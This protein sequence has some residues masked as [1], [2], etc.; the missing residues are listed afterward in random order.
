M[1]TLPRPGQ[2]ER[3]ALQF[4][5]LAS[6]VES[7]LG[8]QHLGGDPSHGERMLHDVLRQRGLHLSRTEDA[9]LS[10]AVRVGSAPTTLRR[11]AAARRQR[12]SFV[13]TLWAG[14]RYPMALIATA[15]LVALISLRLG[16]SRWVPI[17]IVLLLVATAALAFL[18]VRGLRRGTGPW[19]RLP[20]L[21]PLLEQ[22]A[23]LPYLQVLHGLY[24]AGVPLLTAHPQAV[25]ACPLVAVRLRLFA[26]DRIVQQQRPL[27]EAL[28]QVG[29][30][31][32]ETRQLIRTGEPGG[33]LED[34]LLRALQRRMD[35]TSRDTLLF[36]QWLGRIA[37]GTAAAIAIYLIFSFYSAY[38]SQLNALRGR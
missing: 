21:G 37:Y 15:L 25:A 23:E 20:G 4:E 2:D 8:A 29:A 33:T 26:A 1:L 27:S 7:G 24:S 3:H 31:H 12:A 30:L 28:D 13:R 16:T 18:L 11:C 19:L 6:A 14:M 35:V 38:F 10:A 9:I 32:L 17:G 36:C 5:D 34:A 22:L